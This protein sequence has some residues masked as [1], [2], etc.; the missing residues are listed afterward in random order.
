MSPAPNPQLE[1]LFDE[2]CAGN[3]TPQQ[4]EE[5]HH[6]QEVVRE[7]EAHE[8]AILKENEQ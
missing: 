6:L 7:Q 1:D 5:L 4:Y 8:E 3:G 2:L